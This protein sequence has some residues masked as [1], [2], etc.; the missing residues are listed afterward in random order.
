METKTLNILIISYHFP[1]EWAGPAERFLR[2]VPKLKERNVSLH[3]VTRKHS[4]YQKRSEVHRGAKVTRL[5]IKRV[6]RN[7]EVFLLKAGKYAIKNRLE[8]DIMLAM[9]YNYASVPT[10]YLLNILGKPTIALH[11]MAVNYNLPGFKGQ[12]I[13]FLSILGLTSHQYAISS[14]NYLK[15]NIANVGFPQSKIEVI[16]NGVDLNRFQPLPSANQRVS[17]KKDLELKGE[18]NALFV[19]LKSPRKGVL[20]LVKAWKIYKDQYNGRG[21]LVLVGPERRETSALEGFYKEWDKETK[22]AE[23]YNIELLGSKSNIEQ[24]FRT[25]DLFVFL[26]N[27]EGLPNV[28][29][30]SMACGIPILMNPYEGFSEEVAK[31]GKHVYLTSREPEQI[32]SDLNLIINDKVTL[33]KQSTEGLKWIRKMHDVEVSLDKFS[34]FFKRIAK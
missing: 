13:K 8:F 7:F 19:G 20:P 12:L 28:L 15:D 32:A 14:T 30:E 33:E 1:P 21:N 9:S 31:P 29:P 6:K 3:F 16:S 17:L 23:N 4:P 27:L 34:S 2:Y 10:N 26:S 25:C 24:Y 5:E 18:F 22:D 11:T